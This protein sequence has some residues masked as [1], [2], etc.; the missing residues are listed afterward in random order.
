MRVWELCHP[1]PE[2][3]EGS[4]LE[5][6]F[7]VNFGGV[8]ER[9]EL[10]QDVHVDQRYLDPVEFVERTF[11]TSEMREILSSV[12]AKL[13]GGRAQSVYHLRVSM[14]GGKSHTLLLLYFLVKGRERVVP[15]LR[16]RGV[17]ADIPPTSRVVV[18]DGSRI[19]VIDGYRPLE[20]KTLWGMVLAQLGYERASSFDSWDSVPAIPVFREALA[21]APTLILIDEITEYVE[22]CRGLSGRASKVQ[23]FLQN[24]T[25]AVS[26]S[27]NSAMVVASPAGVYEEALSMV[28][29]ILGRYARQVALATPEEYRMIRKR[30][31]FSDDFSSLPAD[32]LEV[33]EEMC[34]I[35]R[36][37][38]P[39]RSEGCRESFTQ[40]YPFHPA[41]EQLMTKLKSSKSFQEVRDELRF[42]ASL[43][44]SVFKRKPD[45]AYLISPCYAD[46]S[47]SYVRGGTVAKLRAVSYTHLTLPTT[48]RV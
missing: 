42:L 11:I 44:F 1:Y 33:I 21:P 15:L 26:E 27:P 38:V 37:Q 2:V 30:A 29:E 14:G 7:V 24:L 31:L 41:V 16:E 10:G 48:E 40:H 4:L 32:A 36:S 25:A 8:W 6:S 5:E 39:S 17:E 28:S 9:L 12:S 3:L 18:V 43:V 23:V 19:D 35:L 22:N 46:L 34:A 47:D 20:V 13:R 45:D